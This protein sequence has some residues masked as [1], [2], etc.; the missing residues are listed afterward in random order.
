MALFRRDPD[1]EDELRKEP[2]FNDA[3]AAEAEKVI[4][5][6]PQVPRIMPRKPKALEVQRDE[7]GVALVN[8]DAGGHLAEWGSVNNPPYAPI[9]RGVRAAG[10]RLDEEA[11]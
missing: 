1:F 7:D 4:G 11:K 5:R 10:L 6:A 3:L 9:R 8:T 2:E